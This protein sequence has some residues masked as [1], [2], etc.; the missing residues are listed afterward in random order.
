MI[1]R[2]PRD[3]SISEEMNNRANSLSTPP[4]RGCCYAREGDFLTKEKTRSKSGAKPGAGKNPEFQ[5]QVIRTT[6]E[7]KKKGSA[8]GKKSGE[9]RRE[10]SRRKRD[11]R[12]A[13]R[14]ILDLAAQGQIAENLDKLG[15]DME[16]QTNMAALQASLFTYA[17]RGDL[18]AYMALMKIAGYDPEENRKERESISSDRRRETETE[19]KV[20]AL[21]QS[22]DG[23]RTSV[24]LKDEDG[25][26]DVHIYLPEIASVESCEIAEE[27]SSEDG[28]TDR[29]TETD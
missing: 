21:G 26:S 15:V 24:S 16:D 22:Q 12:E 5:A 14:F 23:L 25:D 19:A 9:V 10:N 7:A 6:E 28:E 29:P 20:A 17:M 4:W 13:A 27:I 1:R 8:G 11:A 18:N 3:G 2:Y